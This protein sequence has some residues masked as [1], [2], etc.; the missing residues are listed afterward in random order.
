M[1]SLAYAYYFPNSQAIREKFWNDFSFNRISIN[2]LFLLKGEDVFTP[3][4][5]AW[6]SLRFFKHISSLVTICLIQINVKCLE[7]ISIIEVRIWCDFNILGHQN[8][9]SL[10]WMHIFS[11]LA[12]KKYFKIKA[13]LG[14][15]LLD[16]DWRFR[17]LGQLFNV[18]S[19]WV[20]L[21]MFSWKF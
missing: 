6:I 2:S 17:L 13:I 12:W 9:S 5:W 3:K 14:G 20:T 19:S 18:G 11:S 4:I 16:P 21:R 15:T 7:S 10:S 8:I 1:S